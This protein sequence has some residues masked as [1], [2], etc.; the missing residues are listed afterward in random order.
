MLSLMSYEKIV[1]SYL[2]QF[3]SI[4]V[5]TYASGSK[6]VE[7]ATR[8]TVHAFIE[9]LCEYCKPDSAK[10][11]V[12]HEASYGKKN[13]PDWRVE[14]PDT[15]GVYCFGDHKSLSPDG[16][17][18]LSESERKQIARYIQFGRP[19]FVFDGLEFI[20]YNGDLGKQTRQ[21]LLQKPL[22]VE[23]DWSALKV[24]PLVE[25][26]F[27]SL[28]NNPG[29]RK[30]TESQ[31]IEQLAIRARTLSNSVQDLL[32]APTGSGASSSEENLLSALHGLK[33]IIKE[34]HDPSLSDD[35]SC[36][37]FIAQVLTFGLFYAHT[38]NPIKANS[39]QERRKV[40]STFWS[41]S[42]DT[43]Q[44]SKLR[45]FKSIMDELS[46]V[47]TDSNALTSWNSEVLGVLSHAEFMGIE[48]SELD[49]HTLFEAFLD[50]FDSKLRFDRGAFY[51]PIK[52]SNWVVS[53]TNSL[54][55]MHFDGEM[56]E[57]AE[58]IIDPCCGTGSFLEAIARG[59][60]GDINCDLIGLEILPAPY[61]LAH[62]R[63]AELCAK[64]K[65]EIRLQILLVD[66]LSDEILETPSVATDGFSGEKATAQRSCHPPVRVVIG[67]PPS[68]N[69]PALSA[70]REKINSLVS[71]F[72]PPKS[73]LSDRQNIQK[74]LNNE[75]YRFL[76]W[77]C[78]RVLDT[79]SGIVSVIL[80]GAFARSISFKHARKWLLNTFDE[81][82]ILEIDGDARSNDS[83]QS[84]FSVLQGRLALVCIRFASSSGSSKVHFRDISKNNLVEK[85]QFLD[86]KPSI[87]E[88]EE[89]SVSEDSYIFAPTQ[90]YPRDKWATY[91]PLTNNVSGTGIFNEKC[92]AVKLAPTA[93]LFHTSLPTLLR[94]TNELGNPKNDRNQLA[95]KWFKGQR[96]PPNM[97]KLTEDVQASM[98]SASQSEYTATYFFR[99]FVYGTVL[100]HEDLFAALSSAPGGGTR[101]RPEVRMAFEDRAVGLCVAPS[102]IDLG[103]TLT[104]FASFA[105]SLPDNDVVARGNAMVYCD[106]FAFKNDVGELEVGSNVN[107]ALEL[108]FNFGDSFQKSVLFYVY[109]VLSS[110]YYLETFEG[111]LYG[112]SNPNS[113]PRIPIS[114]SLKVREELVKLGKKLAEQEAPLANIPV[115]QGF[116]KEEFKFE[117][118][119]LA[120]SKYDASSETIHLYGDD[121]SDCPV[122]NVAEEVYG[123]RISGHNVVDKW[124]R[125]K[126]FVYYR[127]EFSGVEMQELRQLLI[128]I[129]DQ[130]ETISQIDKILRELIMSGEVVTCPS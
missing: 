48:N 121:G 76:R 16:P 77:C 1:T 2:S 79:G 78:E 3:R 129:E 84:L 27:R 108:L 112:P 98:L 44:A 58:K 130:F 105:W 24:N 30:W 71:D 127:R 22:L 56:Y 9:S 106:Q 21:S 126:T 33:R 34:H 117:G 101:A 115:D 25:N 92:S 123:L 6:S 85:Y 75:A 50:K 128:K 8:P 38:R 5:T 83:S 15:F 109:A 52:L 124:L 11:T 96:R 103:N 14:D 94:R 49:F 67:N 54:S 88:F 61:A 89:I 60:N 122:E 81:L 18:T 35:E 111:V 41:E 95:K 62:Y 93:M 51:T 13:R 87:A 29:Y 59:A 70:P 43:S 119:R 104:R 73:E 107:N 64:G 116:D 97:K 40:I 69:H 114:S 7:L 68:S 19:V 91:W 72:R 46:A 23:D 57:V 118:F 47:S 74:A 10:A 90:E 32:V 86:S 99:P 31:L 82:Y 37:D 36:A 53:L 26:E 125:E 100:Y 55:K 120:K 65:Q 113:P 17:L 28:L 102:T 42:P 39:P 20:F 12:H 4:C 110:A 63:M 66:T 45:P 80:P